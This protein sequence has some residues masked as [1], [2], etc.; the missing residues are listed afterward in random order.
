[1]VS[2]LNEITK[3]RNTKPLA[4]DYSNTNRY[5]VVLNEPDGSKTAY[6][7]TTPVYNNKT[8][9]AVDLQ[10]HKKTG[11]FYSIGSNANITYSDKIRME[12][13]EG[14]C[15]VNL[16]RNVSPYSKNQLVC[17]DGFL[18]PTTNGF[19]YRVSCQGNKGLSFELEVGKPYM[20]IRANNKYF[21]LM[22]E[23]FR[24]F[25]TVSCIGT[26]NERG[27]V[28]APAKISYQKMTDRKYRCTVSPCSSLGKMVMFEIN[29]Y[30]AKLVQDT[31]VE[32]AN[33]K[34]NNAF[35]STA[36]IGNTSEYGEQWLY[37]RPDF[38]KLSDLSDNKILKAVVH[39]PKYNQSNVQLSAFRVAARFCS[40]GSTWDNKIASA[41][42]IADSLARDFYQDIDITTLFTDKFG[43]LMRSEGII[44]R[45]RIKGAGFSAIATGDSY[46]APQIYEINYK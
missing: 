30:E 19:V 38:S 26:T 18:S 23:R 17:G 3:L 40:F 1:M 12:N 15:L 46:Y 31:T 33:P 44:L 35:G 16:N 29:L 2:V 36:F 7:F 42:S 22:S 43:R 37:S 20:E 25:V 9:K 32:S 10:F 28:I 4:L 13:A 11:A 27:V 5:R 39:L 14:Y 45:P 24:P 6:Y 34:T 41:N 8:R 21:S